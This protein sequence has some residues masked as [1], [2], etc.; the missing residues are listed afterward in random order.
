[1]PLPIIGP[2][3]SSAVTECSTKAA[4]VCYG[5]TSALVEQKLTPIAQDVANEVKW[6]VRISVALTVGYIFYDRFFKK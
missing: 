5:Q 6:G 4:K 2:A 3:I 1:M